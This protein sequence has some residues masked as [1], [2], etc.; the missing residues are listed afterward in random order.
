MGPLRTRISTPS[1]RPVV[2]CRRH[3]DRAHAIRGLMRSLRPPNARN[4]VRWRDL[5]SRARSSTSRNPQP[6]PPPASV[7]A[8]PHDAHPRRPPQTRRL[9]HRTKARRAAPPRPPNAAPRARHTMPAPAR[10]VRQPIGSAEQYQVN[11][12]LPPAAGVHR[13][14]SRLPL[15]RQQQPP[16]EVGHRLRPQQPLHLEPPTPPSSGSQQAAS[17]PARRFGRSRRASCHA[18]R[19]ELARACRPARCSVLRPESPAPLTMAHPAS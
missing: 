4:S 5:P 13:G 7:D 15:H 9:A 2:P 14:G 17:R 10:R 16:G 6:A 19:R 18:G 8:E 12:T 11:W 3:S 1:T